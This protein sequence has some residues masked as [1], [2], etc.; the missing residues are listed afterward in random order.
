VKTPVGSGMPASLWPAT[1]T[2][3][4]SSANARTRCIS[5][6][7]QE[8][9]PQCHSSKSASRKPRTLLGRDVRAASLVQLETR[10]R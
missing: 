2:S 1:P 3:L 4:S 9:R 6:E 8:G 7:P 10:C 5:T